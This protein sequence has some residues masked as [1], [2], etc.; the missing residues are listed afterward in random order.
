MASKRGE[1]APLGSAVARERTRHAQRAAL[2]VFVAHA[3][4][5]LATASPERLRT[6]TPFNHFALLAESWLA[7][8]LDL[9]GPPPAYTQGNDFAV[10]GDRTFVSFPP[11]PAVLVAPL[12]KLCGGAANTPDGAFFVLLAAVAPA[13]VLLALERLAAAGRTS[14]S[15]RENVA[16]ATCF[17]LGTVYWFS[18][19][20]GTVWFAAHAVGAAL[21]AAYVLASV[22]A[23]HPAWAGLLLALGFATRTPIAFALPFFLFEAARAASPAAAGASWAARWSAL[24]R[25]TLARSLARFAVPALLVL[26][27]LA[28][29]NH[30]RFGDPFEFGHRHL[31][32][33]WRGR[34]DKWGLFSL[35]YL[36]RNL[37]VML[38]SLPWPRPPLGD[39]PPF[40][41]NAHGLAL[42]VTTPLYIYALWPRRATPTFVALAVTALAVAT[43]SLLYQNSGWIQFGYRFS[44]DFAPILFAMIATSRRRLG[45]GFALLAAWGL[46]ANAFGALTFQRP[47]WD[48]WYVVER[49]QRVIF[50]PD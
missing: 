27:V 41:I 2:V 4:V 12:V 44:C 20:Q 9:G 32:I 14:R 18:A 13:L 15:L 50:Q 6:H 23:A 43:P 3:L 10:V 46:A 25:A 34:I 33:G 22:E 1:S 26:A 36:P 48:A 21:V 42:W 39:G 24:D 16:L 5:F 38:A 8:R 31:A 28:W 30:A 37:G 40:Q 19:V 35:H 47:G 7:G 29:H 49:T 17:G 45:L 11:F